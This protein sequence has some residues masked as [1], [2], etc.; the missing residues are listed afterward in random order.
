MDDETAESLESTLRAA[1]LRLADA[2]KRAATALSAVRKLRRAVQDGSVGTL[3]AALT[4]AT[5]A[6]AAL[7]EAIG[8]GGV[9][10]DIAA[11][12]DDGGYLRELAAAAK[13]AGVVLVQKEGRITCYP[14]VLR[15]DARAQ[16]VRVGRR[17]ERRLRPSVL[18]A[19]LKTLQQRPDR[20]N[21]RSFLDRLLR[22]YAALARAAD[23]AYRADR[24]MPG[25]LV[26]LADLYD[27]LT[28]LPAA[29]ADYPAEEFVCDLLRL[30]RQPEARGSR[31]H[32]FE[33]GGSTG[34]KGA[35]R[36]TLFDESGLQHDYFAIRF[37]L[38]AD[39][40]RSVGAGAAAR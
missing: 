8:G 1:D 6:A 9:T 2:E 30:D 3:A 27:M 34:S 29:A 40:A 16:G 25:P 31:G 21:A 38:D 20:F 5:D 17:L 35:K 4:A 37:I 23:P 15:L 28:V 39:D 14:V 7:P 22:P 19:A 10:Y 36:L 11:A 12:F 33:L 24:P 32:R 26:P 18:V 13:A